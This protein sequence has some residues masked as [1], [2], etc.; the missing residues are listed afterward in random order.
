MNRFEK[1]FSLSSYL[2]VVVSFDPQSDRPSQVP[3]GT[4]HYAPPE[5]LA[6]QRIPTKKMP[7]IDVC[8]WARYFF[9]SHLTVFLYQ[10]WAL[11]ATL[12]TMLAGDF[13]LKG[14]EKSVLEDIKRYQRYS[15]ITC[16]FIVLTGLSQGKDERLLAAVERSC[17]Q[18]RDRAIG[19]YVYSGFELSHDN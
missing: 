15:L 1:Y 7:L 18:G 8:I 19:G 13:F 5:A 14:T 2:I 9:A 3:S 10:V 16:E 6:R 12:F 17:H 11:A 4:L